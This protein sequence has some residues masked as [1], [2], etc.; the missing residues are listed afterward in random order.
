MLLVED[1][2]NSVCDTA[3]RERL[4]LFPVPLPT[5]GW[6]SEAWRMVQSMISISAVSCR[7][8]KAKGK[9]KQ[10]NHMHSLPSKI[11]VVLEILC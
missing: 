6:H 1:Y 5:G 2:S 3:V 9:D 11:P 4:T 7:S 10:L 8:V